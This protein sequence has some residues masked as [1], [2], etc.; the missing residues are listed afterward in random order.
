MTEVSQHSCGNL[1][2]ERI[3]T[4]KREECQKD[5]EI[6]KMQWIYKNLEMCLAQEIPEACVVHGRVLEESLEASA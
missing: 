1:P 2:Q 5:T 6:G 4:E 3:F